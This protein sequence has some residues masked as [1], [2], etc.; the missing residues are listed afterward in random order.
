M[1]GV[2]MDFLGA[3]ARFEADATL[4]SYLPARFQAMFAALKRTETAELLGEV[5]PAEFAWYL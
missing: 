3:L 5:S 1:A 2:P 4:A